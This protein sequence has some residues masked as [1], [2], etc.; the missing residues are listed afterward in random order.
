MNDLEADKLFQRYL[1]EVRGIEIKGE[2][3]M[4]YIIKF[5]RNGF[6]YEAEIKNV[7]NK[8][9]AIEKLESYTGEG[10]KIKK[11]KAVEKWQTFTLE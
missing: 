3:G 5:I 11:I 8:K 10:I 4:I 2:D 1:K 6:K 7:K 9:Q